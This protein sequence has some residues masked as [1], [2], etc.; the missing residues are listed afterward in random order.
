MFATRYT[1]SVGRCK[2]ETL[3]RYI[4]LVKNEERRV[5]NLMEYVEEHKFKYNLPFTRYNL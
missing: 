5:K 1:L 2:A 3:Q 4:F